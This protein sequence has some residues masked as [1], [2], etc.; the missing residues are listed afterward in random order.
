MKSMRHQKRKTKKNFIKIV[1][2]YEV[3][4]NE[5]KMYNIIKM[6]DCVLNTSGE[7]NIEKII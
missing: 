3:E 5:E 2:C 7:H 4:Q 1:D 6:H